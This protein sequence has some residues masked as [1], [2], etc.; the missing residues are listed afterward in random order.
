M[1]QLLTIPTACG[2]WHDGEGHFFTRYICNDY[3]SLM[4][5]LRGLPY[6]PSGMQAKLHSALSESFHAQNIPVPTLPQYMQTPRLASQQDAQQPAWSCGTIAMCTTLHLLLGDHH[7]HE[8]RELYI[9]KTHMLTLHRALLECHILGTT[10]P[11]WQV[12]CLHQN[13]QPSSLAHA[14]PYPFLSISATMSLTKDQPWRPGRST[15]VEPLRPLK[16]PHWRTTYRKSPKLRYS[17]LPYPPVTLPTP[18]IY[19][20]H[21]TSLR[22]GQRY[23]RPPAQHSR[24]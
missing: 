21:R 12:G 13:I 10:P 14:V 24:K 2:P 1:A 4:D 23:R 22:C 9:T 20:R 11:L 7:P 5:P 15:S 3:G 18:E 16:R 19:R 17:P 6:P 8:L